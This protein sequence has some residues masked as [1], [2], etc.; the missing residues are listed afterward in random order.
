MSSA[1]ACH[2]RLGA[3]GVGVNPA[4]PAAGVYGELRRRGGALGARRL[5]HTQAAR[6]HSRRGRQV[7]VVWMEVL[8]ARVERVRMGADVALAVADA[9]PA[10]HLK[11]RGSVPPPHISGL[12]PSCCKT[13]RALVVLVLRPWPR[14]SSQAKVA[15]IRRA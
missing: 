6:A 11:E 13:M 3:L 5:R 2:R 8:G 4:G 9:V 14:L 7:A 15:S 1:A 12:A 10:L